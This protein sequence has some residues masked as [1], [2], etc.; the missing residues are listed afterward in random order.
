MAR[1]RE[2]YCERTLK[3]VV[4]KLRLFALEHSAM[5][6]KFTPGS[7]KAYGEAKAAIALRAAAMVFER[8]IKSQ[9]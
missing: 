5:R 4:R 9:N 8:K 2:D 7:E 1:K 3:E 6:E